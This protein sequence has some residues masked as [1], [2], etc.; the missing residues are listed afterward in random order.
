MFYVWTI[1]LGARAEAAK[2]QP[3]NVSADAEPNFSWAEAGKC[4]SQPSRK[5]VDVDPSRKC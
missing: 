3:K 5:N 1:D 2:V 4:F